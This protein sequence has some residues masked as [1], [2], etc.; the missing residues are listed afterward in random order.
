MLEA[1]GAFII[2][3]EYCAINI[4]KLFGN[5]YLV[6]R[7]T[8]HETVKNNENIFISETILSRMGNMTDNLHGDYMTKLHKA[9]LVLRKSRIKRN[10]FLAHYN[11]YILILIEIDQM[12]TIWY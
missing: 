10:I 6:G 3:N 9:A 5:V 7:L 4:T 8:K 2:V 1:L 11:S 12:Q